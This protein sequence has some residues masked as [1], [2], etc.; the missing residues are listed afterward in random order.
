MVFVLDGP[1]MEN[2]M[3]RE[4]EEEVEIMVVG[5]IKT[6]I[7]LKNAR[8]VDASTLLTTTVITV[9]LIKNVFMESASVI[10]IIMMVAHT[11][12]NVHL[13]EIATHLSSA[14]K[15]NVK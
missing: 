6:V 2:L 3:I 12:I 5:V 1:M 7:L 11:P 13:I 8:E 14:I 15:D 9:N 4:M 10:A